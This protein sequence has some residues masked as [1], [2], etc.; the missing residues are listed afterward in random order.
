MTSPATLPADASLVAPAAAV[1]LSGPAI[2]LVRYWQ[3]QAVITRQMVELA[4]TSLRRYGIPDTPAARSQ[5]A[6]RI[7]P[8]IVRARA[9][10]YVLGVR[11]MRSAPVEVT[12]DV[13][14]PLR[15]YPV[16]AVETALENVID[17]PE[18]AGR[19]AVELVD[20]LPADQP[21]SRARVTVADTNGTTARPRTRARVVVQELDQVSRQPR[22]SITE[23][24]GAT[25]ARHAQQAGRDVVV[26]T[27]EAQPEEIGWARVLSGA[28]NCAWCAM[29]A[30]RGPVYRSAQT[31][32]F[33]SGTRGNQP[34]GAKF[35]N[36]C[37]CAIVLVH[38]DRD[39]NGREQYETLEDLWVEATREFSTGSAR[40]AF[41]R[42]IDRGNREGLTHAELLDALRRERAAREA[43][44]GN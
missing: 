30:S 15:T 2:S 39:W 8:Q 19:A 16:T 23:D 4:A 32:K 34:A 21:R 31:A 20:D 29:L 42:A 6:R 22:V 10:S 17:P 43:A 25:L 40:R 41:R 26:D 35:H 13:L 28:E 18:P 33:A 12:A 9:Q 3:S 38:K 37:D 1:A 36:N 11:Q 5:F 27:A 7:Y 44:E 14:A 24:L